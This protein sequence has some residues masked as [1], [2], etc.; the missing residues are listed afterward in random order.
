ML[1]TKTM[2]TLKE[3]KQRKHKQWQLNQKKAKTSI[4]HPR[5]T[6]KFCEQKMAE[7]NSTFLLSGRFDFDPKEILDK[8]LLFDL[9]KKLSGEKIFDLIIEKILDKNDIYH[10]EHRE[11]TNTFRIRKDSKQAEK[12]ELKQ[13]LKPSIE[14]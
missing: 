9:K 10:I 5:E 1:L 4:K 14:V 13:G 6:K 2:K 8:S 3:K 12:D 11:G 7:N